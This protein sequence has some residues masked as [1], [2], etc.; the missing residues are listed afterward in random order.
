MASGDVVRDA[1]ELVPKFRFARRLHGWLP[2]RFNFANGGAFGLLEIP[3]AGATG[4]KCRRPP[5]YRMRIL[6][7]DLER[8]WRGGQSQAL[9]TLQGLVRANYQVELVAAER[10]PLAQ[11]AAQLGI[12]V[13]ASPR[14]GLR[15]WAAQAMARLSARAAGEPFALAQLNEP[16]AL[17][18][19]WLAGLHRRM[20][21]LLSRR[22]GFPLYENWV[23]QARVPALERFVSD[24]EH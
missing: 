15:A 24:S 17:T 7:A 23:L 13:H 2:R 19:A 10:S 3:E 18:A 11:R 22:I 21:L 9:L 20:P 1:V 16:H 5:G 6:Y 12:P 14:F 4:K 8:E